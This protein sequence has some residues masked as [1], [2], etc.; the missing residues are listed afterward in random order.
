[1]KALEILYTL[2][3]KQVKVNLTEHNTLRLEIP[4]NIKGDIVLEDVKQYKQQIIGIL[5]NNNVHKNHNIRIYKDLSLKTFP[6][7]YMQ[8]SF[9][10]MSQYQGNFGYAYNEIINIKLNA[11][12]LNIKTLNEALNKL[13]ERHSIFRT[14][15]KKDE[16]GLPYQEV[17]PYDKFLNI[18]LYPEKI[19]ESKIEKYL[20][21]EVCYLF[22]LSKEAIRFRLF[23]IIE[24]DFYLLIIVMHH[25]VIDGVSTSIF[26]KELNYIYGSLTTK[27]DIKLPFLRIQYGDFAIWQRACFK[28]GILNDHLKYWVNKLNGFKNLDLF[29]DKPRPV[30][31]S[32]TGSC[33]KFG[34]SSKLKS[35]LIEFSRLHNCSLFMTMLSGLYILFSR[36]SNQNDI[37]IGSPIANR[38]CQDLEGVIGCFLNTLALRV[39][40]RN[41]T[42]R[43][44][45]N[46]VRTTCLEAFQ[47]QVVPFEMLVKELKIERELNRTPIFQVI[48]ILQNHDELLDKNLLSDDIDYSCETV[49][50]G[51]SSNFDLLISAIEFKNAIDIYVEVN[52]D[53]FEQETIKRMFKNYMNILV[54][55]PKNLDVKTENF[56]FFTR[57]EYNKI[58]L[59]WNHTESCLP[60]N[61]TVCGIFE[62]QVKKTP[63]NI[64]VVFRD[65]LI[66][67]KELNE[68]V[69]QLSRYLVDKGLET[70]KRVIFLMDRNIDYVVCMLAVWKIGAVFIPLNPKEF[71]KKNKTILGQ[72]DYQY[73]LTSINYQQ[74]AYDLDASNNKVLF[75]DS[76]EIKNFSADNVG[77]EIKSSRPA[78]IIF[79]SGSTGVPKGAIVYHEGMLNHLLAKIKDFN[80]GELDVVAETAT[81]TFD[82]S[83]WQFIAALLVGGKTQIFDDESAWDPV[84]LLTLMENKHVTIY[85]SVP[86]HMAVILE[87]LEK[88]SPSYK[89]ENLK[90]F[91]MNGEGLPPSYCKR[92]FKLFPNIPMANVYG[93]T[94][95]SDDVTHYK[96]NNVDVN[97][98]RYMPIGKPIANIK[99]YVLD[100][101]MMPTPIGVPGELYIAGLGVGGGYINSKEK[102]AQNFI[103][104][105]FALKNDLDKGE[106]LVLYKTGDLVRY[107]SDG[108]LEYLNRADFQVKINGIRIELGEIEAKVS[109]HEAIFQCIVTV[110]KNKKLNS[111]Q[112][113]VYYQCHKNKKI[114]SEEL[115]NYILEEFP[116]HMVPSFFIELE[117][118]PLNTNGKV[119]RNALPMPDITTGLQNNYIEPR[120][121]TEQIL[122]NIWKEVL[123]LGKISVNYNFFKIGG[124]SLLAIQT[125]TKINN[126]FKKD[127]PVISLFSHQTI[128]EFALLINNEIVNTSD[129]NLELALND[130]AIDIPVKKDIQRLILNPLP[131][132]I[133]LTGITGFLG[134][135]LLED[136]LTTTKAQIF[137]LIRG[138]DDRDISNKYQKTL[139]YFGKEY[140]LDEKRVLL[141]NGDLGKEKL[142]LSTETIGYLENNLDSIYHNGAFVHHIFDYKTLRKTNVLSTVELLK[143]AAFGRGK[144]FHYISTVSTSIY[145]NAKGQVL[146]YEFS[147][148]P[149]SRNGYDMSKWASEKILERAA[150]NGTIVNIFRPG[151]IS[152]N[153]FDGACFP[154]KN[155]V[156]LFI[157]GCIQMKAAPVWDVMIE[158]TPVDIVSKAIVSLSLKRKKN[159]MTYNLS[160]P[161]LIRWIDYLNK[162]NELGFNIKLVESNH[163]VSEYL[164]NID[165]TNA[166]YLIKEF[167]KKIPKKDTY[168]HSL[169]SNQKRTQKELMDENIIYPNADN[170]IRLVAKYMKYL[171]DIK[172]I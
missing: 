157:K 13:I 48:F 121:K 14:I 69:N 143:I 134:I 96:F 136:L 19:S 65:N 142:G 86:S 17:L 149:L 46:I 35:K 123:K 85:E 147:D 154:E 61:K 103:K 67:Y 5:K 32:Y 119:D 153:T 27:Q 51:K 98:G 38:Y 43:E 2:Q 145:H 74:V 23:E 172:F 158:M 79:T 70:Y 68:R 101:N 116:Q 109:K 71:F 163:W 118:I 125:I 155:R 130:I 18:N 84:R 131:Q 72:L 168:N 133:L 152:G 8:E 44:L 1:M 141:I 137:C 169:F 24:K 91:I 160:N 140:L 16:S 63:N 93:P 88:N 99:L 151:Y 66:T 26:N 55:M 128:A 162:L 113:V 25:I 115:R 167:Y 105:P 138:K 56:S 83:I 110:F 89:L 76:W 87:E 64:A 126:T 20:T 78:Y 150:Q 60:K 59:E 117:R 106:N 95:C 135:H 57:E 144:Q 58:L 90:W 129:E 166:I 22:D 102:T 30:I 92:W 31:H 139:A 75:I 3:Q 148:L 159:L 53:L 9:W 127:Y 112:L 122:V 124:H 50:R 114:T 45:L 10:F 146:E 4:E 6:L 171:Q 164:N 73:L 156:L 111:K 37:I 47:H 41:K 80:I 7:S 12:R 107:L 161:H 62:E 42:V 28:Q 39:D 94:E 11:N 29:T 104:N 49:P 52:G 77:I 170:V 33:L 54:E 15:F 165:E 21:N 36:Y 40:I 100:K 34:I 132:C 120:N 108:N 97:A 81:Q 82:V